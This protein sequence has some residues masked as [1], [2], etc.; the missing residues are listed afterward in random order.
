MAPPVTVTTVKPAGT[1]SKLFGLTE[2][3]HLPARRQYLR[4]VQFRT[5]D[6]LVGDYAARG[7]PLRRLETFPGV[8]V[9]GFPTLP[10][11]QRLG[12]GDRLVTAPE[13]TP[14][15]QYRWLGLLERH[16]I[17]AARGNQVSY[18]LKIA[19]ERVGLDEFRA[20]LRVH[21]PHLRCCA[22][23]PG[24]PDRDLGYEYL[25]E[26]EVAPGRFAEIVAGIRDP[27]A[28]EAVDLARLQ[29]EAGVCPI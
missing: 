25:P 24:R 29:C 15:E 26:E 8:T 23:L 6:P 2:G 7:Y 27:G 10:L 19:T 18:T 28:G 5:E 20:L 3:A 17:G 12:I 16:W 11:I 4:W 22:V 14:G 9:V 13:A 1:T 21:Q